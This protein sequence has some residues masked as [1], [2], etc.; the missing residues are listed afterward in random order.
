ML[1]CN[2]SQYQSHHCYFVAY[3]AR[4]KIKHGTIK[5]YL[6]GLDFFTLL[7]IGKKPFLQ[8]MDCLHY[9]WPLR[10]KILWKK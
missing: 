7:K 1:D 5:A 2:H 9:A 8:A 10:H 6:L 4:D 3:L